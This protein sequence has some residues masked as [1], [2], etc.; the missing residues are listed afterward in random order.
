MASNHP[1]I[2]ASI[3]VASAALVTATR[4]LAPAH[5]PATGA[6]AVAEAEAMTGV[7]TV[8]PVV[9][10]A[11]PVAAAPRRSTRSI[12]SESRR[13]GVLHAGTALAALRGT[14]I[15]K[16]WNP[17]AARSPSP[18]QIDLRFNLAFDPAGSLVG[19]GISDDRKAYRT[20][21]SAC[22][23][24]LSVKFNI[25]APGAPLQVQVPFTLP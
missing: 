25:P 5:V 10:P 13:L 20:D 15:E 6:V 14:F 21:V 4:L 1:W 23:R 11:A 2:F 22:L 12:T 7:A 8:A 3:V 18:E 24:G 19:V 9:A 16:C 17:S